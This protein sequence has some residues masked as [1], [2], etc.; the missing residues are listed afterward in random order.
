MKE[1]RRQLRADLE[2][3]NESEEIYQRKLYADR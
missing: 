1:R 3:D 2:A